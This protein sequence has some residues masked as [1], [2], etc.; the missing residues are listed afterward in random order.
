[1]HPI[2]GG[3]SRPD[4]GVTI[5]S[6]AGSAPGPSASSSFITADF[7]LPVPYPNGGTG[8]QVVSQRMWG[9]STGGAGNDGFA[10]FAD[11]TYTTLMGQIDPGLW[12]FVGNLAGT[13]WFNADSS[14]NPAGW[15]NLIANFDKVDPLGISGIVIG[16]DFPEANENITGD[17]DVASYA[18]CLGNLA[19]YLKGQTMPNGK[20]L[21]VLGFTGHNEPDGFGVG[22]T[23]QYYDAFIPKVKAASSDYLVFG[24]HTSYAGALMPDFMQKVP[25]VDVLAWDMFLFGYS[26]TAAGDRI[27]TDPSYANRGANDVTTMTGREAYPVQALMANGNMDWNCSDPEQDGYVAAMFLAT[28]YLSSLSEA[29]VPLWSGV[30]D[31]FGDG[32]CGF[33]PDPNN[34]ATPGAT[35]APTPFAY[36]VAQGVRKIHGPRWNVPIDEAGLGTLAVTPAPGRFSLMIVNAGQGDQNGAVALS[37]WPASGDGNG[38]A[39]VWQMTTAAKGPGDD[40]SYGKVTVKAGVTDAMSF[41]DPSITILSN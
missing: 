29:P 11:P 40:G 15:A 22:T 38:T 6:D 1:M 31:A 33:I 14:V 9:A 30:W 4:G 21:P 27:W 19:T 24:P 20:P 2:G 8:Q 5:H 18:N 34:P 25:G 41:P 32:T 17:S 37:H 7:T 35:K 10:A 28:W 39:N 36:L 3:T 23:A 16:L 13:E 26:G 12:Y